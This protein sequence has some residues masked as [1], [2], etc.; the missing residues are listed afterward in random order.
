MKDK[1]INRYMTMGIQ[2][3]ISSE[4]QFF[5][6]ELQIM[7]R[8][9]S[10]KFDYLQVYKLSKGSDSLQVIEHTAEIPKHQDIY[11]VEIPNLIE[12]IIYIITDEYEDCLV[13]TMLF[14][15]ER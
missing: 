7:K 3:E 14:P 8:G 13:E 6:W 10:K 9:E 15:S 1:T 4:L 12:G 2:K 11:Y 5:L